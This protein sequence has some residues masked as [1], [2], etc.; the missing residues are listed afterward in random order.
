MKQVTIY[1]ESDPPLLLPLSRFA[2]L[3][4]VIYKLLTAS[5]ALAD[6]LHDRPVGGER[7]Y[8]FFCF[9]DIHGCHKICGSSIRYDGLL[10][11]Q[12]RAAD[13]RVVDA[14][15]RVLAERPQFSVNGI[16]CRVRRLDLSQTT[17]L[18]DRAVIVMD[19][20][21]VVYTTDHSGFRTFYSPDD[22]HFFRAVENNLKR[23]Y[24]TFWRRR[25]DVPVRFEVDPSGVRKKCVTSFKGSPIAGYGGQ[26]ILSAPPELLTF[27][28]YVG[29]GGKNS[30]GFGTIRENHL[31]DRCFVRTDAAS[32]EE[33]FQK[34]GTDGRNEQF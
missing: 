33:L 6:E 12:I 32:G 2:A 26:Y 23:K 1:F 29:L 28:Y 4:G 3:Q 30:Q 16:N 31:P 17:A 24:E 8:K 18:A 11:W 19:T 9:S 13:D 22:P 15:V 21:I 5:P 10:S 20:P 34:K 25:A 14:V 27:A 7:N